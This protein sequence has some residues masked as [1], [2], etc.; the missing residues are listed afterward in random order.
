[1]DSQAETVGC[2]SAEDAQGY[3]G[4]DAV[5]ADEEHEQIVFILRSKAV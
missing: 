5:D 4:T 3:F 1:M 2:A